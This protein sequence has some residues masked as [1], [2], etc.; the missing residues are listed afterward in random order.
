[1]HIRNLMLAVLFVPTAQSMYGQC[2]D[3]QRKLDDLEKKY[4][5]SFEDLTKEAGIIAKDLPDSNVSVPG[6]HISGEIKLKR[7]DFAINLISTTM[8]NRKLSMSIPQAT[9]RTKSF[10]VPYTI[11]KWKIKKLCCGI[12]T[13]V[14]QVTTGMKRASFKFIDIKMASRD[15]VMKVPEFRSERKNFSFNVPEFTVDSPIPEDERF[16]ELHKKSKEAMQRA[17]ALDKRTTSLTEE[18]KKETRSLLEGMYNCMISN[19]SSEKLQMVQLCDANITEVDKSIEEL[20]KHNM[21][22]AAIT[23]DDGTVV[24][25]IRVRQ[26][27]LTEKDRISAEFDKAIAELKDSVSKLTIE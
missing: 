4:S 5:Q 10:S 17:E 9:M 6:H 7:K 3:E 26:D 14:P 19:L 11:T 27:L 13:K 12:K 22:P 16:N 21:N 24:N 25:L 1:M 8:K 2:T 15:I 20:K 18:Q 23:S